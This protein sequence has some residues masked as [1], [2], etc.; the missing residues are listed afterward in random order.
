MPK[1]PMNIKYY[2]EDNVIIVWSHGLSSGGWTDAAY[3][4]ITLEQPATGDLFT[5]LQKNAVKQ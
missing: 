1:I 2:E 5:W 4:T 3:R